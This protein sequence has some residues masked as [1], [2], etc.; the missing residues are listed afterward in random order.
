M[1]RRTRLALGLWLVLLS[2]LQGSAQPTAPK[3][4]I[5]SFAWHMRGQDFGGFSAIELSDDG[6]GFTALS[7][8]ALIITGQFVRDADGVI[9][10]ITA[11]PLL[12][13][14]KGKTKARL[15]DRL[16]DAEGLALA[17]DGT[18][19]VSFE[20]RARVA[21]LDPDLGTVKDLPRAPA[22]ATMPN[23]ASLEALA[24][25]PDGTVF[26]LAEHPPA[27]G[28]L[29]LFRFQGGVWDDS[30]RVPRVGRFLPVAADFGPDGRLYLLERDF[31]G[32]AGFSSRL[33]RFD[34]GPNGPT[35]AKEM[36]VTP[37]GLHDN[38]EGLSVW[39]DTAGRL[40]ATMIADDNYLFVL[41][42]QI[43]EYQLPD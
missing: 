43:V 10:G 24:I 4:L 1:Q 21:V 41:R 15:T 42:S 14:V 2:G 36:F 9:T 11:G 13:L 19:F 38:L 17:K 26:T 40:R 35:G 31:R 25:A 16:A 5:G 27:T 39:R 22:F 3:G 12:P 29:P 28:D 33:R 6:L 7:D 23:N 30:Q 20:A 32:I 37:F 8:K 18:L 34:M